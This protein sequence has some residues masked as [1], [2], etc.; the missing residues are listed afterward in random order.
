M[1]RSAHE[2]TQ[3]H[4]ILHTN[5][6]VLSE[7]NKGL[8]DAICRSVLSRIKRRLRLRAAGFVFPIQKW[9]ADNDR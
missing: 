2:D 9:S 6:H 8:T 1:L 5:R 3:S 7:V 4:A